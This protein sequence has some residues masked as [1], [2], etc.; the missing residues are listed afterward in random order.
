[1]HEGQ[2]DTDEAAVEEAIVAALDGTVSYDVEATGLTL[3]NRSGR[4]LTLRAQE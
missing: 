4:G 1:M 2:C 3:T